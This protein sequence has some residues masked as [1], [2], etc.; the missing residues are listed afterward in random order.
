MDK[1]NDRIL[2]ELSE[3]SNA[4]I[5]GYLKDGYWYIRARTNFAL[6]PPP[7]YTTWEIAEPPEP[8]KY[9]TY[10][11]EIQLRVEYH[12]M[13]GQAAMLGSEIRHRLYL[14]YEAY[15]KRRWG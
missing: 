15:V 2:S 4:E 11:A 5:E 10:T 13:R 8:L 3:H 12:V 1:D 9:E 7:N 6:F 14:A